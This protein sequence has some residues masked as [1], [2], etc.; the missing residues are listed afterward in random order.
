MVAIFM[1]TLCRFAAL[2]SVAAMAPAQTAPSRPAAS[3]AK[4]QSPADIYGPLF[5]AVQQ[6]HVFADG[7][8]F[9]DAVP[10]RAAATIIADYVRTRPAGPALK[11]FVLANFVVPGE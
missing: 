11:A 9:D 5:Q 10:K 2:A 8:T 6:G 1:K 3:A 7:K 4:A